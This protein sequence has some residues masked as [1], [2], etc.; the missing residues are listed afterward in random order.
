MPTN[1]LHCDYNLTAPN[2]NLIST[3]EVDITLY[4]YLN[5]NSFNAF[6]V[7]FI[8]NHC[9]YV[10][11]I[12]NKIVNNA[13][14]LKNFGV[15]SFAICSNDAIDYPEDSFENMKKFSKE[16]RLPFPYLHDPSQEIA[17]LYGAVCTPDFFGF[18]KNMKLC[19]RGR[20]D[21]STK[22]N[23]P[24]SSKKEMFEAMKKIA[25]DGTGPKN[26]LPSIGCSIK[27]KT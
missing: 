20:L 11:T 16:K 10:K 5:E 22:K 14:D 9:P 17:K 24:S 2:F 13:N 8:C 26:Q 6:L 21:D 12:I 1:S 18:N 3:E 7:M 27:W 19:Y 15:H 4:N 23:S 25:L